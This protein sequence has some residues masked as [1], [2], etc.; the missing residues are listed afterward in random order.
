MTPSIS[1]I[2]EVKLTLQ[3]GAIVGQPCLE[4]LNFRK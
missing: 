2:T 3:H 4:R 1:M